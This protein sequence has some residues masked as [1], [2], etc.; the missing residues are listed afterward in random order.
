MNSTT[1][2]TSSAAGRASVCL[3]ECATRVPR[4]RVQSVSSLVSASAAS[5]ASKKSR[6]RA[7]RS[8]A[9]PCSKYVAGAFIASLP[10]FRWSVRCL[11]HARAVEHSTRRSHHRGARLSA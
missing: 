6:A 9:V 2:Y 11:Q 4:G 5:F 10:P 8:A 7:Q 1:A 3:P